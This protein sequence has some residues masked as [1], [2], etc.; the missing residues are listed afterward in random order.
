MILGVLALLVSNAAT[1]LGA[2]SILRSVRTGKPAADFVLL[3]LI[4][5]LLIS[6]IILLAGAARQLNAVALGLAGAA[7]FGVLVARGGHRGMLRPPPRLWDRWL[8]VAG[9]LIALRLLMQVWYFAPTFEDSLS[10]HLPKIAEWVRAGAIT[11]EL[12]PDPRASFPAGFELIETW[13]VIFLHHDALIEM[14]GIEFL[15]VGGAAAYAL[16]QEFGWSDRCAFIASLLFILT[17]GLHLQATSCL[18]DGA[19]AALVVAAAALLLARVHPSLLLIPVGLGAGVKPTFFYALPGLALIACLSRREPVAPG[20]SPRAAAPLVLGAVVVGVVWYVRNWAFYGNPIH[21]VGSAGM[22]NAS[23]VTLQRLGPSFLAF[24]ENLACFID[25]RVYDRV[26]A[27]DALGA[28]NFNWGAAAFALGAPA[29]I[30]VLR[31]E[32]LFRRAAL[33]LTISLFSVFALVE[34]DPWNSRFVLFFAV[35]PA[36]ALACLWERHRFMAVLCASALVLCV[37][38]TFLPAG[39][40][41]VVL[42]STARKPI[43][44]RAS[45]PPPA[46]PGD[47]SPI[48][49]GENV[50]RA[51]SLYG[52]DFSRRVVYLRDDT[53]DS[54]LAHLDRENISVFYVS[55]NRRGN[56]AMLDEGV[57]RGRLK[58]LPEGIW[59]GYVVERPR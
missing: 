12:G 24:R 23:G 19:V 56:T 46:V 52:P 16:A 20:P 58:P 4:R 11:R 22:H 49:C 21:P 47:R 40:P 42:A 17:P 2:R 54:L 36:L 29:M 10:Y 44:E 33:G 55:P 28:G 26:T 13:W 39:I 3:L 38:T 32:R 5:L 27:P 48:G 57:R 14:A 35:L 53:I 50:A 41:R 34:M 18:N 1:V 30:P 9:G 45:F 37:G 8:M 51:Y 43:Q 15:L 31:T 25:I 59:S 6:V 7:A